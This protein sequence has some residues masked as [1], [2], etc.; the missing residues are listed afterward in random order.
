MLGQSDERIKRYLE[1]RAIQAA[2]AARAEQER[3]EAERPGRISRILGKWAE[4]TRLIVSILEELRGKLSAAD[5]HSSFQATA[6][7]G[8][9]LASA[10][11]I[12]RL[13]D[14]HYEL[15]LN[16]TPEGLVQVSK[17]AGRSSLPPLGVTF[18]SMSKVEVLTAQK[19]EYERLI[20][21]AL[22]IN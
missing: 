19:E 7:R 3:K 12:G 1:K 6:P 20:L 11:I 10:I 17:A 4:D 18:V 21:D 16:I 8:A 14:Q 15:L 2:E 5:F 22:E 9:A 13:E